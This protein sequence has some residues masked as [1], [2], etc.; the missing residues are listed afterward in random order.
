MEQE[1]PN[2]PST[3]VI[4]AKT[5]A[6]HASGFPNANGNKRLTFTTYKQDQSDQQYLIGQKLL[7]GVLYDGFQTGAPLYTAQEAVVH[8]NRLF[9]SPAH[10]RTNYTSSVLHFAG[11]LIS[12]MHLLESEYKLKVLDAGKIPVLQHDTE[13][14]IVSSCVY[15]DMQLDVLLKQIDMT[16][17]ALES[18]N[19]YG[20]DTAS[21]DGILKDINVHLSYL[22]GLK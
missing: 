10:I 8:N 19:L 13:V 7:D 17:R 14:Q 12:E 11:Q 3:S 18:L 5:A 21:R 4:Q 6:A 1:F 22:N 20:I 2:I 15:A 16:L 9:K